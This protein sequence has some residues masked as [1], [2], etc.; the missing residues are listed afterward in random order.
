MPADR[1]RAPRRRSQPEWRLPHYTGV[2]DGGDLD[3]RH[4]MARRR[5]R[6]WHEGEGRLHT[7]RAL[8]GLTCDTATG[9]L[10][11]RPQARVGPEPVFAVLTGRLTALEGSR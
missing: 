7:W 8:P 2:Q 5:R 3:S 4:Y 1:M 11:G 9:W 10:F 6:T